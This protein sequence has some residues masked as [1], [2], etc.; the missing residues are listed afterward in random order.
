LADTTSDQFLVTQALRA[1]AMLVLGLKKE[2]VLTDPFDGTRP[3]NA[4]IIID[5]ITSRSVSERWAEPVV[6]E[7]TVSVKGVVMKQDLFQM[8]FFG[9]DS[10]PWPE[11]LERSRARPDV[12]ALFDQ[13]GVSV[14]STDVLNTRNLV[15]DGAKWEL[16]SILEIGVSYFSVD[17]EAASPEELLQ[18]AVV[19]NQPAPLYTVT[20]EVE[21]E[22]A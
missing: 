4:Y 21:A 12:I 5:R 10:G 11:K 13:K 19:A 16:G 18:E 8:R 17:S 22:E 9:D 2:L 15:R 6:A 1:W 14:F 3:P 7:T 20:V